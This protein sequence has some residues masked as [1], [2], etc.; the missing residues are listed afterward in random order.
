MYSIF[1]NNDLK[2]IKRMSSLIN[3]IDQTINF[4]DQTIR[5]V[6]TYDSPM[7]VASDV[8]K[9]LGLANVT[10]TLR[11][12]P[13]KWKQICDLGFSEVTSTARKTQGMNCIT[14]AG[15]Y[16]IIMRSNKPIAQKFQEI[17]CEEILPSIRKTGEFKL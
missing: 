1:L 6:G 12:L 15:L 7:F 13:D 17:V 16:K 10:D 8:C 2:I 3:T 9:I 14:E 4:N 5:I 11:S